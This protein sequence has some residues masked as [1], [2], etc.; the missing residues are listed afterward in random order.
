MSPS[1][2][3]LRRIPKQ[4]Y[5]EQEVVDKLELF[6]RKSGMAMSGAANMIVKENIDK[7]I[8]K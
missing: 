2:K 7:Y 8:D 4:T 5:F 1:K 6:M 3:K